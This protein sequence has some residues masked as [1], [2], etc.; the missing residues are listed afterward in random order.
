MLGLLLRVLTHSIYIYVIDPGAD[1][2]LIGG[3]SWHILHFSDNS[4]ELHGALAGMGSEVLPSVDAVTA[5]EDSEGRVIL[6]VLD[7]A[8]FDRR[9]TQNEAKYIR[10]RGYTH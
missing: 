6:L 4:E 10:C 1:K 3:V 8:A 5:V 2:E 7:K 9:V